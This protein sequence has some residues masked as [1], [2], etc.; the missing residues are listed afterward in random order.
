MLYRV[1][2]HLGVGT[3]TVPTPPTEMCEDATELIEDYKETLSVYRLTATYDDSGLGTEVWNLQGNF[4]GDWQPR[5]ANTIRQEK[6]LEIKSVAF[7]IAGCNIDVIE[8]D[9]IFRADSSFEY[10]NYVKI[11]HGHTT[12]FV[13]KQAGSN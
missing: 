11:Y 12:I 3:V 7:I 6:G 5:S 1:G 10:V 8:N 9:R 4:E 2:S 13:K